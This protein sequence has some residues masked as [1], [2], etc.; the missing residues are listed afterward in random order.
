MSHERM[1]NDPRALHRKI[2]T[3]VARAEIWLAT[4]VVLVIPTSALAEDPPSCPPTDDK[5]CKRAY[6]D[7]LKNGVEFNLIWPVVPK[8]IQVKYNRVLFSPDNGLKGEFVTSLNF[9][10]WTFVEGEGE[11]LMVAPSVGYRQYWWRGI[12]S[13]I[14]IYPEF[15]WLRDNVVDGQ[16]YWDF[17]LIPEFYSGYK[18]YFGATQMF[19]NLQVGLGIIAY[20][21][22][23]WP[24]TVDDDI[25]FNGNATIGI[26]F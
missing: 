18:G 13:E 9:R 4:L 25:F 20:R 2:R 16:S 12:N 21:A 5:A 15:I 6:R 1:N 10:P 14:A 19:Y 22:N 11:K 8:I 23:P 7:R 17:N 26:S 24:K 3:L